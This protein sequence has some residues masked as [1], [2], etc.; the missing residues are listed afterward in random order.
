MCV[1]VYI[2][3]YIGIYLY[4]R[5]V[6]YVN[7]YIYMR[8]LGTTVLESKFTLIGIFRDQLLT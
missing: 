3:V 5:F 4:V 1:N 8:M 7:V 2:H 6:L